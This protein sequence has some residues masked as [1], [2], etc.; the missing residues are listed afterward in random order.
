MYTVYIHIYINPYV[1]IYLSKHR[2]VEP[3][4]RILIPIEPVYDVFRDPSITFKE[5]LT[6]TLM[7]VSEHRGP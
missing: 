1:F 5:T 2:L 3:V 7:E 4:S 6:G